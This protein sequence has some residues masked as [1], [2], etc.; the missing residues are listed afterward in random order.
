VN[1]RLLHLLEVKSSNLRV[2]PLAR[3]PDAP[4]ERGT[5]HMKAL[6]R[7][8]RSGIRTD[9]V[10]VVQRSDADAFAPN[11][12]L[13]PDFAEAFDR[14]RAAGVGVSA[15]RLKVRPKEL[16][17]GEAIPVLKKSKENIF[18]RHGSNAGR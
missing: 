14:A 15:Y 11:R 9:V 10:I 1:G 13:D 6:A 12:A 17:W 4:T 18:N 8:C 3:F 5:R 16:E 2:G 7:A